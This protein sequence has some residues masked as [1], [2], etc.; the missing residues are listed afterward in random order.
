MFRTILDSW[1]F[2]SKLVG[3]IK[4]SRK[5]KLFFRLFPEESFIYVYVGCSF[6]AIRVSY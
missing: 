6:K 3:N 4:I 1:K 5:K 2:R